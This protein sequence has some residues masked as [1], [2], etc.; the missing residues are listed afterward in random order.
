MSTLLEINSLLDLTNPKGQ[1]VVIN[2]SN[3]PAEHGTWITDEVIAHNGFTCVESVD[4]FNK[5][6]ILFKEQP[7][8]EKTLIFIPGGEGRVHFIT[9]DLVVMPTNYINQINSDYNV[10]SVDFDHNMGW[11]F[12]RE[13]ERVMPPRGIAIGSANRNFVNA[14]PDTPF[15]KLLTALVD[16]STVLDQIKIM[17]PGEHWVAGHCNS[18]ELLSKHYAFNNTVTYQGMIF[19]TPSWRNTWKETIDKMN[20]FAKPLNIPLLTVIHKEDSAKVV[21]VELAHAITEQSQSPRR[22]LQVVEGGIDCGLPHFSMGHHGYFGIDNIV[23]DH[24]IDFVNAK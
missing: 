8:K 13:F 6:R 20:Y 22:R 12:A 14:L 3:I 4:T 18:C 2:N 23:I 11:L 19:L 21:G 1:G 7:K 15:K 10:V 9:P 5:H 17:F 16:L 24:I